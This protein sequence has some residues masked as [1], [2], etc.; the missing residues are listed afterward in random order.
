MISNFVGNHII[1]GMNSFEIWLLMC[2]DLFAAH[3]SLG[4]WFPE[5]TTAQSKILQCIPILLLIIKLH[6]QNLH[7]PWSLFLH[8]QATLDYKTT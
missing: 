1:W 5:L 7:I 4:V 8:T 6:L 3:H 2:N